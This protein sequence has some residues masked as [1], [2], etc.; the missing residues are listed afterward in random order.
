M[1]G[2]VA[3]ENDSQ[4]DSEQTPT[5]QKDQELKAKLSTEPRPQ[6]S[7]IVIKRPNSIH[8]NHLRI[9][10]RDNVKDNIPGPSSHLHPSEPS[11][12]IK[13]SPESPQEGI[14]DA[15]LSPEDEL[16]QIRALLRPPPISGV[17]D[18]GIPPPSTEPC[19][20]AIQTKLAQFSAL[21]HDP[22][23]PKH[24]NDSLMSNRSFRNPH[25]YAKLVEF[26]DVD[27]RVTNFPK[28]IWDPE[29][30]Q[31]EWF[32]DKIATTQ[33]TGKRSQIAFTS[34]SSSSSMPISNPSPAISFPK[35]VLGGEKDNKS[36]GFGQSSGVLGGG[37]RPSRFQPY[38]QSQPDHTY[39]REKEK[40][41][42]G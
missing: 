8:R 28:H 15:P 34:S 31:E 35:R 3:Y 4:S 12:E 14:S 38:N 13:Y 23:N 22:V 17:E 40:A 36:L 33:I 5:T 6:K 32:A 39:A 11:S 20:P 18:W 24:F 29:D 21:K 41:R 10:P 30:V 16:S 1:R 37:K 7:Q 2:L 9:P 19:S 42:Y 27:E 26:V 25:L